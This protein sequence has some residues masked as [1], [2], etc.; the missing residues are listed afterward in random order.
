MATT[1]TFAGSEG[2]I[3]YHRWE[4]EGPPARVVQIVH[5]YA[6]HGGRYAHVAEA[7]NRSGAIVYADDHLGHGRS[8]GDRA[9]IVDFEHVVDDLAS[10]MDIAT[11]ENPGLPHVLV[12][13]SMGGLLA[14]LLAQRVPERVTAVAFCGSVIGDW[15]WAREV[16]QQ[17][18]LPYIPFDPLAI[19][20]DPAVGAGV[21]SGPTR[22]PRPVQAQASGCRTA[23][24]R[25]FPA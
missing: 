24:A 8:D 16:L 19:S 12:G 5:G 15:E 20:R 3:F 4:P 11:T 22:L 25:E 2:K 18:E 1:A 17:P 21:R 23:G 7:L 10:L 14:A 13:H 9:L 6:E